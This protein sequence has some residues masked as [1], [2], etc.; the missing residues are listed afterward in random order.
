MSEYWDSGL[1]IQEYSE[2]K[3]LS[4]ESTRRW[5]RVLQKARQYINRGV[6]TVISILNLASPVPHLPCIRKEY[7]IL[8]ARQILKKR[9]FFMLLLLTKS[10]FCL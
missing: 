10:Q 1:T 5:I 3:E 8:L 2:L 4:Y 9:R 6:V 7:K